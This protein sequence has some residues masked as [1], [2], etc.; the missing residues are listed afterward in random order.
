MS[1]KTTICPSDQQPPE[2]PEMTVTL[3]QLFNQQTGMA[4]MSSW[5]VRTSIIFLLIPPPRHRQRALADEFAVFCGLA[6][7]PRAWAYR[8][9]AEEPRL[10]MRRCPFMLEQTTQSLRRQ[11]IAMSVALATGCLWSLGKFSHV[12]CIFL[13]LRAHSLTSVEALT[14]QKR[15]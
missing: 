8:Y 5:C 4:L 3:P 7:S 10:L 11:V 6:G 12:L 1:P 2:R 14:E 15:Y 9:F 13:S